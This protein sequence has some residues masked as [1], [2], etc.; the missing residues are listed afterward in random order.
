MAEQDENLKN[1]EFE[2]KMNQRQ[3]NATGNNGNDE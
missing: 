1:V 2:P 3:P